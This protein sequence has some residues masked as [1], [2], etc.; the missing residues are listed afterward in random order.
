MSSS[1]PGSPK[2]MLSPKLQAPPLSPLKFS[3][4]PKNYSTPSPKH[5]YKS[6]NT[7]G[8]DSQKVQSGIQKFRSRKCTNLRFHSQIHLDANKVRTVIKMR[9]A[10]RKHRQE[11]DLI[12][13]KSPLTKAEES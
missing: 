3:H 10:G 13:T 11:I 1:Q 6:P 2:Q 12:S 5:V 8:S 7:P 9:S 4:D